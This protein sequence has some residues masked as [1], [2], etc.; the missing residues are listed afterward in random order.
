MSTDRPL[1]DYAPPRPW[2]RRYWKRLTPIVLLLAIAG[3]GWWWRRDLVHAWR[4]HA[5]L[6]AERRCLAFRPEP[7]RVA[8]EEDPAR[9][10]QLLAASGTEYL[11]HVEQGH[12]GPRTLALWWPKVVREFPDAF[13]HVQH[14]GR[15]ALLFLHERTTPKGRRVLV[16]TMVYVRPDSPTPLLTFETRV[17]DP[18]TWDLPP[19][20]AGGSLEVLENVWNYYSTK[21]VRIYAGRPDPADPSRLTIDFEVAGQRGVFEGRVTDAQSE[22][23]PT[24]FDLRTRRGD[25]SR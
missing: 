10:G 25:P 11:P 15:K 18:A 23:L 24:E 12:D 2:A 16:C 6:R 5:Y 19:R 20:V 14:P 17:S 22:G 3:T 7:D 4:R 21:P 8:Y 9:A 1:L 13:R